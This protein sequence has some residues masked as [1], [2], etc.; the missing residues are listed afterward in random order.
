MMLKEVLYSFIKLAFIFCSGIFLHAQSLGGKILDERNQPITYAEI[1]A[2]KDKIKKT[3]ISDE[4]GNFIIKLSEDGIYSLEIFL[5]G[6]KCYSKVIS[7][8]GNISE[9]FIINKIQEKEI[10]GVTIIKQKKIIERKVDRLIFNVENS[11]ISQ[12]GDGL[13]VLKLTPNISVRNDQITMIGKSGMAIM[14][15][16]R[17]LKLSGDDLINYLKNLKSDDIKSIEVI[18]NPP[19]KYDAEGNSGIININ[20]KKS[21]QNSWN[22]S[23]GTFFKQSKYQQYGQSLNINYNRNGLSFYGSSGRND[24]LYFYRTEEDNIYYTDKFYHSFSAMKNDL[25]KNYNGNL[26]VDYDFSK[27]FSAGLQFM[28]NFNNTLGNEI[29]DTKI[30][31]TQNYLLQTLSDA[32]DNRDNYSLNFHSSYKLDSL[33]SNIVLNGDLFNYESSRNR[34]FDTRQYNDFID[35][36]DRY[37]AQNNSSQKIKNYSAQIDVEKK[38]KNYGLDFGGKLSTTKNVSDINFYDLSSGI[39]IFQQDKSDKFDYTENLQALYVSGN[40]K[41]NEKWETK[42]GF[43]LENTETEGYSHNL[44]E[45]NKAHYL[46]IFPTLYILYK[47]QKNRS[48]S[49]NYGKR[50]HR[51]SYRI[52]NPFVRYIN[53]YTTSQGNPYLQP[54]YTDNYEL[55]YNYKDNWINTLYVSNSKNI[56]EQVTYISNDNINSATKYE[57]FYK[58]FSIGLTESYTFHLV[59][60]WETNLT[61]NIYYKKIESS[62]PQTLPSFSG[63]SAFFETENNYALNRDKTILLSL[64][65]WCQLPQYEAVYKLSSMSSLDFGVKGMFMD[66]N[67]VLSL[68]ANDIFRTLKVCNT[69]IINNIPQKFNNYEDRQSVRLSVKYSFGNSKVKSKSVNSSNQEEKQRAN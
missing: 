46:K 39:S 31:S 2:T 63:W 68:Y 28:K 43:R 25:G 51:P 10:Q 11:I 48:I 23:I 20:L 57:N 61:A 66:K 35:F 18:T 54:Y 49:F 55:A 7:V 32:K 29:N 67:L 41:I 27:N 21:R 19:A 42:L 24:R 53:P 1:V 40:K 38:F 45:T 15:N 52:L 37:S 47:P 44:N 50:I 56:Y 34:I 6:N 64:D 9:K 12:G 33:G 5:D 22:T 60:N 3:A 69:F 30:Y 4:N 59:K 13:D 36:I 17:I 16:G 58:Q 14:L 26:G 62:L 65:Y 8:N